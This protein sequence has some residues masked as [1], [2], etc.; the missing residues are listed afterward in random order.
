[1]VHNEAAGANSTAFRLYRAFPVSRRFKAA[2]EAGYDTAAWLSG[3]LATAWVTGTGYTPLSLAALSV[4]VCLTARGAGCSP[5]CPG[6]LLGSRGSVLA[7]LS[8]QVAAGGPVTVTH[9][10][11]TE[12]FM[13]L[14]EAIG[15]VLQAAVIG[16][17]RQSLSADMGEPVRI[18]DIA[19]RLAAG[20]S[21]PVDIVFPGLR[22]GEKL[23]KD[24]L[25]QGEV[26]R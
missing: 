14:D 10:E 25:D 23:T 21:H 1:M 26:D 17:L 6:N 18:A 5:T 2:I 7:A 20:A 12:Y 13:I 8:A 19:R 16:K 9:S 11:V 24:V 3:L 22:P 4:L 15:L